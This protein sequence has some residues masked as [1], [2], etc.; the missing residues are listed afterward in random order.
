MFHFLE[1]DGQ[2]D[3]NQCDT[4]TSCNLNVT[5]EIKKVLL[6]CYS[7]VDLNEERMSGETNLVWTKIMEMVKWRNLT[8]KTLL[9]VYF[10]VQ[11]TTV[12]CI[13]YVSS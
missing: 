2:L 4:Q 7:D 13:N 12:L 6:E 3:T 8:T 5:F 1:A 10:N 11:G 9:K